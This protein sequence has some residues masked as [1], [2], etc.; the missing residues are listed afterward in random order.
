MKNDQKLVEILI[1]LKG[2]R[3]IVIISHRP[4]FLRLCDRQLELK[5]GKLRD[6]KLPSYQEKNVPPSSDVVKPQATT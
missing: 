4:S 2:R 1:K 5:S 6:Y 3:T